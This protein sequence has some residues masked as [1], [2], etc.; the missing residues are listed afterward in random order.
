MNPNRPVQGQWNDPTHNHSHFG[1]ASSTDAPSSPPQFSRHMPQWQRCGQHNCGNHHCPGHCFAQGQLVLGMNQHCLGCS[2]P[3]NVASL[4]FLPCNHALCR[5]CL[6][7]MAIRIHE[8]IQ[9]KKAQV[10]NALANANLRRKM[11]ERADSAQLAGLMAEEEGDIFA[12]ALT[13]AGYTCCGQPMRL[14]GYLYC[15][16]PGVALI[17]WQDYEYMLTPQE[18]QNHCG[19]PDCKAFV[20]NKCGFIDTTGIGPKILHCPTCNGNS[21]LI[22]HDRSSGESRGRCNVWIPTGH[23]MGRSYMGVEV[24]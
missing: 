12:D 10:D 11:S 22:C 5:D 20:P 16:D 6:N 15:M 21:Q 23:P 8:T 4:H 19:W 24:V 14:G 2:Q 18:N 1:R 9:S 7:K 13:L 17:F 3:K